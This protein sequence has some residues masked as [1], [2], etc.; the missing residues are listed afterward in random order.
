LEKPG[1]KKL[2]INLELIIKIIV[3]FIMA[4]T[5]FFKCTGAEESIY[6]FATLGV[7]PWGRYLTG[8][9][10]LIA[11][12]L[13]FYPK[14]VF[15]GAALSFGIMFGAIMS[16]LL[17]LGINVQNDDG[18]LFGLALTALIGSSY[19]LYNNRKKGPSFLPFN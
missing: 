18:L 16:H 11:I 8:I 5:L 10:E 6:I 7:E 2:K 15:Y 14:T 4:Q 12:I 9:S 19:I 13:L 1:A 17:F 3:A